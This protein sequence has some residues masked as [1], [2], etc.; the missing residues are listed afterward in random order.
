[1]RMGAVVHPIHAAAG[2]LIIFEI[3]SV[4]RGMP[5]EGGERAVLTNYY[6]VKRPST[7]C[8]AHA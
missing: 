7:T 5:C 1:M 4:H 6:R 2:A 3:S 8:S